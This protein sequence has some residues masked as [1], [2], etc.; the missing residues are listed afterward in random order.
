MPEFVVFENVPG[1][2]RPSF[3][4]YF[5]YVRGTLRRPGIA[6]KADELWNEHHARIRASKAQDLYRVY[7][8][9]IDAADVGVAQNRRRIFLAY[10]SGRPRRV[11]KL[12]EHY[13]N[14]QP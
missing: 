8:D 14:A 10:D 4:P 11:G 12:D 9:Q 7:Q 1:L 3:S 5:D 13:S 2:T 6:P